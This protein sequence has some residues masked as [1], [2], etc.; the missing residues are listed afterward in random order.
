MKL[1]I[2]GSKNYP[3]EKCVYDVGQSNRTT[4]LICSHMDPGWARRG[5]IAYTLENSGN[6]MV[7][8]DHFSKNKWTFDYDQAEA[9]RA[10]LK[11]DDRD[12]DATFELYKK[13]D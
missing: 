10:L 12:K 2:L 4:I 5:E 8:T 11:L 13:E 7:I 3:H 6:D 9:I 1:L